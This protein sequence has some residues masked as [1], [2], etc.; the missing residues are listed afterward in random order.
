MWVI[1]LIIVILGLIVSVAL[2]EVGHLVPAKKFGAIVPEYWV[3][4]GPTLWQTKKGSTTYGIKAVLLGGYVRIVG[5]FPG[6]PAN[7]KR[8]R[9]NGQLTLAEEAREQSMED[10]AR[11]R[12]QGDE[13]KAFYELSTPKKLVVMASGPLMNLAI[14]IVL[15]AVVLFGFGIQE[16]TTTIDYV[17]PTVGEQPSPAAAAGLKDGDTIVEWDGTPVTEWDQLRTLV[18]ET[19]AEATDVVVDRDGQLV[20]VQVVPNVDEDGNAS[21]GI[22]SKIGRRSATV[23]EV[24]DTVWQQFVGTGKAIISLPVSLY[25]L[26]RSMITGEERDSSG[27]VSVVGVARLAGEIT[28]PSSLTYEQATPSGTVVQGASVMERV[29]LLIS[30]LA[31]LNMALFVFNLIPLPPLDGGHIVGA[32]WG[33]A[34]NTHAKLRKKP[35][36]APADTARMMPLTYGVFGA[37]MIITVVLVVADIVKPLSLT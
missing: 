10:V 8:Y 27:V 22:S 19:P 26:G 11:A 4:F 3:G 29:A 20:T 5:M 34:K 17:A 28:S 37:L 33:G 36:P 24:A 32:L 23:G 25:E 15:I 12:A 6:G 31:A 14:A 16:P 35:R 9:P 7:R 13:G 1:G 30:L 21:I 2:H 18:G